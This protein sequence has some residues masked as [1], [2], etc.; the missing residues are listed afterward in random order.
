MFDNLGALAWGIVIFAVM[1]VIGSI[2]LLKFGDAIASCGGSYT[3]NTTSHTCY[4][5]TG[6]SINPT[7][8]EWVSANYLLG[9]LGSTSGGLA[10]YTP[11]VI[12]SLVGFAILGLFFG[13]KK[14][15]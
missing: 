10:S 13:G 3:F 6:G 2:V 4:N 1:V 11:L 9:Q 5:A 14:K 7:N 8:T 15:Y 12:I